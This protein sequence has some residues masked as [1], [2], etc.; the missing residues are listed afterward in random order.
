MPT[1]TMRWNEYACELNA[2]NQIGQQ[3][4]ARVLAYLNLAINNAIRVAN[5]AARPTARR[6]G[7]RQ[8]FWRMRSL[9]T[10]R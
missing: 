5:R 10:R 7:L 2:R 9:T 4:T 6:P 3:R 1:A 8:P